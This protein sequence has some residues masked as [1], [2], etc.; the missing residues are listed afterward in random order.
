MNPIQA[1]TSALANTWKAFTRHSPHCGSRHC[2]FTADATDIRW[3]EG[4]RCSPSSGHSAAA[5]RGVLQGLLFP[6]AAA[7]AE[8][9]LQTGN[10]AMG[11]R[12]KHREGGMEGLQ[13]E[14]RMDG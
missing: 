5:D 12:S 10:T 4:Q 6:G 11:Q 3:T 1:H 14:T 2:S 9:Q 13:M 7:R 8:H